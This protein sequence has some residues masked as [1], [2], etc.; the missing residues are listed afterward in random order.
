MNPGKLNKRIK[1]LPKVGAVDNDGYAI[2]DSEVLIKSIWSKVETVESKGASYEFEEGNST[3]SRNTNKFTIRFRKGVTKEMV[4]LF[5][6]RKFEIVSL[7]NEN[8]ENKFLIIVG[9]SVE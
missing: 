2:E 6:E 7:I 3:H 5:N 8:E 4:I 1:I 9:V